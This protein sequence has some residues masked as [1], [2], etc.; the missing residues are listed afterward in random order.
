MDFD[1]LVRKAMEA[2]EKAYAPYSGFRVGAAVQTASGRVYTGCNVENSSFGATICAER[3]AI[4]KAVSEGESKIVAV[5][6]SSDGEN[7]TYPCGIC[8]QVIS[9]FG[10]D[11]TKVICSNKNGQ[12]KIY[13][14]KDIL[15]HAFAGED[16]MTKNKGMNT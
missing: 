12:Y 6:V 16:F 2:K 8:R 11:E 14:M 15:P 7:I 9:E 3:T 4:A 5:A 10:N 13:E 1:Y